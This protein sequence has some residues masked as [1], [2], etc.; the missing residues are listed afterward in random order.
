MANQGVFA[1]G[2][3]DWTLE[4]VKIRA[5]G[6]AGWNGDIGSGSSNAGQ[7]LMRE[8]EVSWNGCAEKYPSTDIHACWAQQKGGY[9]D[10]LGT[11]KTGGNWVIEDS[12]FHHN[13]SDGLDLLYADGTGSVTV[14]RVHAEGNA[15]NQIKTN[16]TALIE[17]SVVVGNCNYFNGIGSM[18]AGDHCRA[19]GN[20][21]SAG[22]MAG[23]T[24]TVRYNTVTGEGDCLILNVG[25]SSSSTANIHNNALIGRN[26]SANQGALTCGHYSDVSAAKVNFVG[27]LFYNV[28]SGQCPSGSICS[29]PKVKNNT[30]LDKFDPTPLAGSPLI[31]RANGSVTVA[32][33]YNNGARPVGAGYDIGAIEYG[34]TAGGGGGGGGGGGRRRNPAELHARRAAAGDQRA[35]GI[36]ERRR[37][38]HLRRDRDQQGRGRLQCR[39]VHARQDDAI[40]LDRQPCRFLAQHQPGQQGV[41]DHQ[42][43]PRRAAR[44]RA[45]T[46]STSARPTAPTAARRPAP[47]RSPP[48]HAAGH[49][50]ALDAAAQPRCALAGVR[51]GR[52]DA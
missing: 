41:H 42:R 49:L 4:R 36:G 51:Q 6:W 12:M 1:G 32:T 14:R 16:G 5:N 33:D 29:D 40:G 7:I 3:T 39:H 22:L 47:T 13:T 28:R 35:G 34:S 43:R 9:G 17:N 20:A 25:G 19:Q 10:G 24:T 2:L 38:A 46:A 37:P 8:V 21:I 18:I 44:P 23:Q 27:N 45:S 26:S 15:G 30:S 11:A 52:R 31:D 48:V 50:H